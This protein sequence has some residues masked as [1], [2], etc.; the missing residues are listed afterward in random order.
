MWLRVALVR[1]GVSE[2]HIASIATLNEIR[3]LETLVIT[4]NWRTQEVKECVPPKRLFLN[5]TQRHIPEEI[6]RKK[7]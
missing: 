5:E 2:E 1:T 7:Y 4:S 3:E 6:F